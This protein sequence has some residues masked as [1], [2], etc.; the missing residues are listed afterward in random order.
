MKE[1]VDRCLKMK[2]QKGW[3]FIFRLQS[4]GVMAEGYTTEVH[5]IMKVMDRSN[6][7]PLFTLSTR[8]GGIREN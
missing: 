3:P 4:V 2:D 8:T 6:G 7:K 5:K 1:E